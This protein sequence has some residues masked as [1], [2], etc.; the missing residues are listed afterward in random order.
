VGHDE[1]ASLR[2]SLEQALE[3]AL[4]GEDVW[5]VDSG[6]TDDSLELAAS[7]T[8]RVLE[9]P[10]GKGRAIAAVLERCR[11]GYLC[12]LDA[13]L[14]ESETNIPIALRGATAGGAVDM[15]VGEFHWPQRRRSVVPGI[16]VPIVGGLFPEVLRAVP[17]RPTSGFRV[18]NAELELGTLPPGYGVET[19]LNVVLTTAGAAIATVPIGRISGPVPSLGHMPR[20]GRDVATAALDLAVE[21]GRLAPSDRGA[22]ERWVETV[23][24]VVARQPPVG[25]PDEEFQRELDEAV[26]RPLPDS[27]A[28]RGLKRADSPSACGRPL[29]DTGSP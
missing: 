3:A 24:E 9:A 16:Y 22:W 28:V 26:S 2:Y 25:E 4:P 17:Y 11:R 27:G 14:T 8:P 21:A 29:G 19:H 5:F 6:S 1:A 12:L 20:L 18:L 15:L 13:D 23:L 10:L 7:L